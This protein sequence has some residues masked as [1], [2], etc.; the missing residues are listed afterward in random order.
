LILDEWCFGLGVQ[1]FLVG[2]AEM[3]NFLWCLIELGVISHAYWR[4]I[5]VTMSILLGL[6][7]VE[8]GEAG[9]KPPPVNEWLKLSILSLDDL[10]HGLVEEVLC[11]VSSSS[12]L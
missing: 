4:C 9:L 12:A 11:G 6:W 8:T 3:S 2:I 10:G 7:L 5:K 1:Q